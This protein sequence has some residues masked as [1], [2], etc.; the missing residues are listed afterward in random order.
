MGR[1]TDAARARTSDAGRRL[2]RLPFG[3]PHLK[4][5]TGSGIGWALDAMDVGLISFIIAALAQQWDLAPGET[6]WIASMSAAV[7]PRHTATSGCDGWGRISGA[8]TRALSGASDPVGV[9]VTR[10]L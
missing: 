1:M 5:L 10:T 3:R 2:D 6:A 9:S 4:V 7:A 8:V